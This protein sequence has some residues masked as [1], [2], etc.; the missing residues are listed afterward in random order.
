MVHTDIYIYIHIFVSIPI[1]NKCPIFPE[2]F[3]PARRFLRFH[4]LSHHTSPGG[5]RNEDVTERAVYVWGVLTISNVG[6]WLIN[7]G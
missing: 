2:G 5:A 6:I 7:D 3:A 1:L 4:R